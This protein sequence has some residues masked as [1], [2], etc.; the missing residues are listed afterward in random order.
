MLHKQITEE[1]STSEL[2]KWFHLFLCSELKAK[3]ENHFCLKNIVK[4]LCNVFILLNYTYA[5]QQIENIFQRT[6]YEDKF[7][8]VKAKKELFFHATL[9]KS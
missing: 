5:S 7:H 8:D 9:T 1:A 2:L 3:K 6:Q 4:I